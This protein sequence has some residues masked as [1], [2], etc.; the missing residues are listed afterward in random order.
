MCYKSFSFCYDLDVLNSLKKKHSET[1]EFQPTIWVLPA[2]L[3]ITFNNFFRPKVQKYHFVI[4]HYY[5]GGYLRE[6]RVSAPTQDN[7]ITVEG[8][9]MQSEEK[10]NRYHRYLSDRIYSDLSVRI[11]WYLSCRTN[12]YLSHMYSIGMFQIGS[13][14]VCQEKC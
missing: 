14:R 11:Y 1:Q 6:Q 4:D 13:L 5:I 8:K 10:Y 9:W 3:C 2:C 7:L 12:W